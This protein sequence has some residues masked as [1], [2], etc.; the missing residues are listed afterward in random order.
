ME[1]LL[2]D[3]RQVSRQAQEGESKNRVT[4]TITIKAADQLSEANREP[5]ARKP[6]QAKKK[7]KANWQQHTTQIQATMAQG[8]HIN[9]A[10]TSKQTNDQFIHGTAKVQV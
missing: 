8:E 1:A 10:K 6:G 7:V 9:L 3:Q 5:A 2:P 4:Q